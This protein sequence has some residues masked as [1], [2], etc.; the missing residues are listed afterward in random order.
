MIEASSKP[1]P[2]T[3]SGMLVALAMAC[4]AWL[5][6]FGAPAMAQGSER[7]PVEHHI[8]FGSNKDG[9]PKRPIVAIYALEGFL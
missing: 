7:M 5:I 3:L 4:A 9:S 2:T 6:G 1:Y 8:T